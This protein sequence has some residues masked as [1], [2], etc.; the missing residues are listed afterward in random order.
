MIP[1]LQRLESASKRRQWSGS[2]PGH[3]PARKEGKLN[4]EALCQHELDLEMAEALPHRDTLAASPII[5]VV[6]P[7]IA[8]A[9]QTGVALAF[10]VL[11]SRTTT[12]ASVFNNLH[13]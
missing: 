11:S 2:G 5:I 8:V 9:A 7:H 10:T 13:V 6:D 4:S 3:L 12:V 1:S